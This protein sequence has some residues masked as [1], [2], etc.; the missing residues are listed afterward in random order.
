M[1]YGLN[2]IDVELLRAYRNNTRTHT[3]EQI[4]MIVAS[5]QEFGWT[6]PVIVREDTIAAGHGKALAARAIYD[7][8]ASIYPAPGREAARMS[9][10][11]LEPFPYGK[12]PIIDASGWSDEQLRAY[13]L[14]DNQIALKSGWDLELL[15]LELQDLRELGFDLNL[16]GFEDVD[17]EAIFN[18]AS[19]NAD[20]GADQPEYRLTIASADEAEILAVKKLLGVRSAEAKVQAARVIG[21]LRDG[22]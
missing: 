11:N 18:G 14:A 21:W 7:R 22:S 2:L 20:P 16:T 17:L 12:V 4:D 3:P 19:S 10:W 13:V 6:N 9:G 8:G 5:I 1:S 15:R